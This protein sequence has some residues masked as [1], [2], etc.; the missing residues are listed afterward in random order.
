MEGHQILEN[1]M[2]KVQVDP[3]GESDISQRGIDAADG[4]HPGQDAISEAG[5]N[6]SC[7]SNQSIF[8]HYKRPK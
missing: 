2:N 5:S 1:W 3:T 4:T 7:N 6:S 8:G